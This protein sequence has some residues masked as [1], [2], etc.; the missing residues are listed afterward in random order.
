MEKIDRL[1]WTDGFSFISYGVRIGLRTNNTEALRRMQESLPPVWKPSASGIVDRL[2]SLKV[3]GKGARPG[4]RPYNLLYGDLLRVSRSF[5]LEE[6]FRNFETDL[7][8]YIAE[9]SDRRVFVHAGVVGWRGR[10]I[11]LPGRTFTG[12]TTLVAEL[13][14]AGATYYSDEYALLDWNGRVYPFARP[15]GLR[16]KEGPQKLKAEELGGKVGAKPLPVSLVALT[17][18]KSGAR[19][20]PQRLSAGRGALAL[21]DN[22][23]SMRRQPEKAMSAILQVVSQSTVIKGSRGEAAGVAEEILKLV[24]NVP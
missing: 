8:M 2:Y 22:T 12:K 13:V 10:A 1:G 16:K 7:N 4:L 23:V 5:D 6:V 9:F 15:L 20:R 19:W 21:L 3:A 24:E 14:R 17:T 11:L 18:Y